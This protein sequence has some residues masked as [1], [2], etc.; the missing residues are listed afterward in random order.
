MVSFC[1][2]WSEAEVAR[3]SHSRRV[4]GDRGVV[5]LENL[6]IALDPQSISG[7]GILK[8][9]GALVDFVDHL[10]SVRDP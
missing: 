4:A 6:R 1:C 7:F 3:R 8:M 2:G 9:G 5:Q 10:A